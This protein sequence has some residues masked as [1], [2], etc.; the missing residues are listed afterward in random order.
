MSGL[1]GDVRFREA[2]LPICR[3]DIWKQLG[4]RL[5]VQR[6]PFL[7]QRSSVDR[8]LYSALIRLS[9]RVGSEQSNAA[10]RV[11]HAGWGRGHM[12]SYHVCP[13]SAHSDG[14]LGSQAPPPPKDAQGGAI[15]QGFIE[16]GLVE[17]RDYVLQPRFT[18]GDDE[19]FPDLAR[20]LV[21]L[22]VRIIC[23]LYTSPSPRD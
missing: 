15:V 21:Q 10:A 9:V 12:A 2:D 22:H 11:H 20:E 16:N 14:F 3:A 4:H 5:I 23:L 18:G 8:S 17:G 13:E 19:R 7:P 1:A 6:R